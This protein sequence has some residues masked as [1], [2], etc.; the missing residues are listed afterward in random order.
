MS[1]PAPQFKYVQ[2]IANPAAGADESFPAILNR[3]FRKYD[4][5]WD[6]RLTHKL[7]DGARL[8]REALDAGAD[9]IVSYGG[10]GT[11]MDVASGLLDTGATMGILPGGTG[12][13]VAGA[14]KL[15]LATEAAVE[16]I[17]T[18]AHEV[19]A[20]DAAE[21][22]GKSFVLRADLGILADT[23]DS[24]DRA[25]K[26]RWG[27]LAYALALLRG[28]A[29]PRQTRF[30]LTV[31]GE[32]VEMV[33]AGCMVLNFDN[34]GTINRSLARGVAADDGLLDVFIL[35]NDALSLVQTVASFAD[36]LD[37]EAL[38]GRYSGKVITVETDEP[39][40]YMLD[41]DTEGSGTTPATFKV[42]PGALRI[43]SPIRTVEPPTGETS[44]TVILPNP[45]AP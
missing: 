25:S 40:A 21:I 12:N 24:V 36:L 17:A 42:L 10:D 11:V 3:V 31:D 19:H 2:V 28:I 43:V 6:M 18:G 9:C 33:G 23:L 39:I 5:Q 14:M 34:I 26:D 8:A 22:N 38:F 15:P 44:E 20:Y 45:P 27:A 29:A 41:G 4:I 13:A 7:G 1:I 30:R 32:E 16:L 37:Y 35:K